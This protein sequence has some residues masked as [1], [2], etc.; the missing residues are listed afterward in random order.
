[1]TALSNFY[2]TKIHRSEASMSW[3]WALCACLA[4]CLMPTL[5]SAMSV[6]VIGMSLVAWIVL[7]VER[8][9]IDLPTGSGRLAVFAFAGY[10]A[11]AFAATQMHGDRIEGAKAMYSNLGFIVTLSLFPVLR[12]SA[13]PYWLKWVAIALGLGGTIVGLVALSGGNSYAR[14]AAFVG[15]PQILA[16]LSACTALLCL[17]LLLGHRSKWWP[18]YLAG[19]SGGIIAMLLAGG[20]A[21][22]LYF[23]VT[24]AVV[25][26]SLLTRLDRLSWRQWVF[27]LYLVL[28]GAA[29]AYETVDDSPVFTGL[30]ARSEVLLES[31]LGDA[32]G[33]DADQSL[34]SRT[35][36]LKVG[37][38][39]F[40]QSPIFGVGRQHLMTAANA[41]S[42]TDPFLP[43]THLHNA[44]LTELVG[45][46]IFG[47]ASFLL[48]LATPIVVTWRAPAPLRQMGA[49]VSIFTALFSLTAIGFH[50]DIKVF[51]FCIIVVTLNAL[52]KADRFIA[53]EIPV[54]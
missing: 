29:V 31:V 3:R 4:L 28:C 50:H 13:M 2:W 47:L 39:A 8:Q 51:Y 18:L 5:G 16:Y 20:R 49:A 21:A 43:Y 11:I 17:C 14:A 42:E 22:I 36:M 54:N 9:D 34:V 33:S 25:A 10:F 37:W 7:L 45:S 38:Q 46:G 6:F 44:Y 40:V 32:S 12:H 48:V 15:N 24:G 27:T 35:Q 30:A 52:A 53:G 19:M 26:I 1:M 23:C 41:Q